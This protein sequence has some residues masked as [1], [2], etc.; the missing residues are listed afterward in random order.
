MGVLYPA[1]G[2]GGR[3]TPEIGYPSRPGKGYP[4]CLDLGRGYPHL[5]LGRE[6]F[7]WEGWGIPPPIG[8]DGVLPHQ[9][10]WDT[11]PPPGRMGYPCQEG[12]VPP[13]TTCENSTFPHS[14]DAGGK[15]RMLGHL[16]VE[17]KTSL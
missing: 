13:S 12:W 9:E 15:N 3:V 6:Y 7:T 2:G 17:S 14:W 1:D 10:G 5:N 8:K 4:L 16:L 11:D